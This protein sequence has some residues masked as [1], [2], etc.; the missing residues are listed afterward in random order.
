[1]VWMLLPFGVDVFTDACSVVEFLHLFLKVK[2]AY[3]IAASE[4]FTATSHIFITLADYIL[5]L[6]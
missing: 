3:I 1:M 2:Y 5:I 6:T 4:M